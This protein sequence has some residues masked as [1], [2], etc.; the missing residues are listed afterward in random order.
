VVYWPSS[1]GLFFGVDMAKDD[2]TVQI[3]GVDY[4]LIATRLKEF[5]D[6]HPDWSIQTAVLSDE[7]PLDPNKTVLVQATIF[8]AE[9][10]AVA[11]GLA[12]EN[13]DFGNI[14]AT[15][16][17][18][19]AETSAVGRALAFVDGKYAGSAI[20]SADE[21]A[22]A[23][24]QQGSVRQIKH[25]EAVREHWESL[26]AIKAF[27]YEEN[28]EAALEAWR[29]LGESAMKVLWRAPS[30]GGVFTTLERK[31][32]DQASTEDFSRRKADGSI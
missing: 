16:A 17:V 31:L 2:G 21:M 13:R 29:E 30:K 22:N 25:M 9:G 12:E 15:S 14:N 20:R 23:L 11:T 19:N 26:V 5:R 8:N 7:F 3:H 32:L 1:E 18:E 6:D 10:A 27:L 4:K 24:K 28:L